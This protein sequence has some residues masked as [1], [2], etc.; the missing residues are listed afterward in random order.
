MKLNQGDR[1]LIAVL[2]IEDWALMGRV[3]SLHLT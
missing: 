3:K 2:S 1:K